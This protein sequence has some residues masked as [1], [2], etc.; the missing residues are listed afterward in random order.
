M[1]SSNHYKKISSIPNHTLTPINQPPI[2]IG[3]FSQSITIPVKRNNPEWVILLKESLDCNWSLK[4]PIRELD[5][6]QT[7]NSFQKGIF[8]KNLG[9]QKV[10]PKV[11]KNDP[12]FAASTINGRHTLNGPHG[13]MTFFSWKNE[14]FDFLASSCGPFIHVETTFGSFLEPLNGHTGCF[15]LPNAYLF[16]AA[17]EG[18]FCDFSGWK[19]T[20]KFRERAVRWYVGRWWGQ[21]LKK[22]FRRI[23]DLSPDIFEKSQILTIFSFFFV[24]FS[25]FPVYAVYNFCPMLNGPYEGCSLVIRTEARLT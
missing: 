3:D 24:A 10:A 21:I 4:F 14:V 20:S 5:R 23:P 17:H 6:K 7:M 12:Y 22:N 16:S 25:N 18:A 19:K 1:R 9:F 13:K 8:L 2:I 15:L 11:S